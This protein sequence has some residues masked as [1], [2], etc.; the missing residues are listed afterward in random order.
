M[1]SAPRQPCSVGPPRP[2]G[3]DRSRA[4]VPA[5]PELR[6]LQP[7]HSP[8]LAACHRWHRRGSD[9]HTVGPSEPTAEDQHGYVYAR[10][11]LRL[12]MLPPSCTILS[13]AR[14][15]LSMEPQGY[16]LR[17]LAGA[18]Q[19]GYCRRAQARQQPARHVVQLNSTQ[20]GPVVKSG[21]HAALSRRRSRVRI[22][23]GPRSHHQMSSASRWSR[24]WMR[25]GRADYDK[26][27]APGQ[28]AQSVRASA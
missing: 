18:S 9:G 25:P 6:S 5:R 15:S 1:P 19:A 4:Q 17:G 8:Q 21:V 2:P 14:W 22:P 11:N 10:T 20:H 28:V 7:M 26:M 16:R 3:A 23:S 12:Q 24:P 13:S 27:V